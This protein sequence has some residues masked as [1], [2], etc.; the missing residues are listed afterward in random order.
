[1]KIFV[2]VWAFVGLL[3]MGAAANDSAAVFTK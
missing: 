2:Q 3:A 1:M